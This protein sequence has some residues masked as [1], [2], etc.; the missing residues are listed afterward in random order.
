METTQ[1]NLR[2]QIHLDIHQPELSTPKDQSQVTK[3]IRIGEKHTSLLNFMMWF[4]HDHQCRF[5][6]LS[7][8]E[9]IWGG[10]VV[11]DVGRFF[12][13]L[14]LVN[15]HVQKIWVPRAMV[16]DF[17]WLE[18]PSPKTLQLQLHLQWAKYFVDILVL[19][20]A[21]CGFGATCSGYHPISTCRFWIIFVFYRGFRFEC[22][23]LSFND[24]LLWRLKVSC[25]INKSWAIR[26]M[27]ARQNMVDVASF[28]LL[29]TGLARS[30]FICQQPFWLPCPPNCSGHEGLQNMT[31]PSVLSI[32]RFLVF[33]SPLWGS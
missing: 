15:A 5:W 11:G 28:F 32:H 2:P 18:K 16:K 33:S 29:W 30:E 7:F 8:F 19:T 6:W 25:T 17:F 12:T 1:P 10:W 31:D 3:S 26:R 20:I 21:K 27:I 14:G 22:C 4:T 9:T 24:V 13:H 23:A